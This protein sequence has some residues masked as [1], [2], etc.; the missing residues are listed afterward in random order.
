MHEQKIFLR[1]V[2]FP[3]FFL[4]VGWENEQENFREWISQF[5]LLEARGIQ[6]GEG[7]HMFDL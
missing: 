3:V 2:P 1:P 4:S 6:G 5:P 7:L